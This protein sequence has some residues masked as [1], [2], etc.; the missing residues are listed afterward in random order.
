MALHQIFDRFSL[1]RSSRRFGTARCLERL[2]KLVFLVRLRLVLPRQQ[3]RLIL[4][5]VIIDV[6]LTIW[7]VD[8][9]ARV[10]IHRKLLLIRLISLVRRV[11]VRKCLLILS[12]ERLAN[13]IDSLLTEVSLPGANFDL[14]HVRV[15]T[16]FNLALRCHSSMIATADC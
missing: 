2:Q 14:G 3:C 15:S 4:L 5:K 11:S 1:T 9:R 6:R 13:L 10:Q 12:C 8:V 16:C 7:V